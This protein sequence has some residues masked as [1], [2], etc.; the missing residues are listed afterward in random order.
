LRSRACCQS[1][2]VS[3]EDRVTSSGPSRTLHDRTVSFLP[4]ISGRLPIRAR[5]A[6]ARC[7]P[8]RQFSTRESPTP[9]PGLARQIQAAT[10]T[11]LSAALPRLRDQQ[12]SIFEAAVPVGPGVRAVGEAHC[13]YESV[14]PLA[15]TVC[16]RIASVGRL[17]SEHVV[18]AR[19]PRLCAGVEVGRPVGLGGY[20]L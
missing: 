4:Q 10:R 9:G 20:L 15:G 14:T 12:A 18:S 6:R 17:V 8:G 19:R 1:P 2:D 13:C 11:C 5:S 3:A 7:R 16:A